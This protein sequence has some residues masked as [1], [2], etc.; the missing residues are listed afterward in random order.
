MKKSSVFLLI[1]TIVC[2]V[3]FQVYAASFSDVNGHWAQSYINRWSDEKIV[4]GYE[5]STFKPNNNITRAEFVT[6]IMRIFEP[7]KKADLSAYS[8]VSKS[9][10]YYDSL[11]R[12]YAVG[13]IQGY[14]ANS[15]RPDA[16]IT[17]QEAVVILNRILGI[18]TISNDTKFIDAIEFAA[19]AKDA[20]IAFTEN[21]YINGYEDGSFKPTAYITRAEITKIL[22]KSIGR[23][24]VNS[25][26]FDLAGVTGSVVVKAENVSLQN[27]T[28]VKK[29]FALNENVKNS[30]KTTKSDVVQINAISNAAI[31]TAEG[32]DMQNANNNLKIT[33]TSK[34]NKYD[35]KKEGNV[36]D[37]VVISV[38][39]DGKT[40]VQN[41][42]FSK[43]NFDALKF[44]MIPIINNGVKNKTISAERLV[45]TLE[46][47][48]N[49]KTAIDAANEFLESLDAED[50]ALM[51]ELLGDNTNL[52]DKYKSMTEDELLDVAVMFLNVDY[53]V[54]KTALETI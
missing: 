30:L 53:D 49:D 16:N 19:W 52:Y 47:Y 40:L 3:S 17:R 34:G 10:W 15:M 9:A 18:K 1:I 35:I 25:G 2:A 22:D 51:E 6:M 26:S 48:K 8:D 45:R 14:S 43:A 37:G 38:V 54:V 39:V 23:I 41:K 50:R 31:S 33:L 27:D 12:G 46:M 44:E 42:T 11:S 32:I 4:N 20:I 5:D 28:N 7:D 24:I 36:V 29:V 13:A 21:G